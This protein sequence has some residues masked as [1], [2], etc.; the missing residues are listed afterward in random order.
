MTGDSSTCN[1]PSDVVLEHTKSIALIPQ[2]CEDMKEM[3]KD[4]KTV[5]GWMQR[6]EGIKEGR[7]TTIDLPVPREQP[8]IALEK[9]VFK[10]DLTKVNWRKIGG[11]V[12]WGGTFALSA[13]AYLKG[14]K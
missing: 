7:T 2:I 6:Q 5:I 11:W 1:M 8:E 12:A 4:M 10:V 14:G 3:K 9:G 13:I